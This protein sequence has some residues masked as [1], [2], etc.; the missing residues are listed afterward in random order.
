MDMRIETL[1]EFVELGRTLNFTVAARNLD[2]TQP[3][4]SK[5][6]S[7][8]EKEL[9]FDLFIRSREL[10]LAPA[11]K[12]YLSFASTFIAKHEETLH[13]CK[14]VSSTEEGELKIRPTQLVDESS[15]LLMAA[16]RQFKQAHPSAPH[17]FVDIQQRPILEELS[18]G[19]VDVAVLRGAGSFTLPDAATK[20]LGLLADYLCDA[21]LWICVEREHPLL[22]KASISLED[23]AEYP[24]FVPSYHV[25]DDYRKAIEALF[26]DAKLVLDADLHAIKQPREFFAHT[27]PEDVHLFSEA[28]CR[29]S[30]IAINDDYVFRPI[31]DSRA[32]FQYYLV[33][34]EKPANPRTNEFVDNVLEAAQNMQ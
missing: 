19:R 17:Q 31:D 13:E 5:H 22:D 1:E 15:K 30:C 4:L 26:A 24:I 33:Y 8:L 9:G 11:G 27:M 34:S 21:P 10:D 29:D 2:I 25:F 32:R 6:M 28:S 23:I 7:E 3:N 14:A 18:R 12:I 20:S 16:R